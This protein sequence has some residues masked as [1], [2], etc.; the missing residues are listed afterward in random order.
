VGGPFSAWS[1]LI[2]SPNALPVIDV[3]NTFQY[4]GSVTYTHGA[5]NFK[6]GAGLIRRQANAWQDSIVAGFFLQ[7]GADNSGAPPPCGALPYPDDRE[8]FLTGNPF[9]EIR[10]DNYFKAGYRTWEPSVLC[11]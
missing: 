1:A 8:N 11:A 7:C 3:N 4:A 10:G 9:L 6:I 2:G 5:H